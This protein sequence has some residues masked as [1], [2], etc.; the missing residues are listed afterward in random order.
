MLRYVYLMPFLSIRLSVD[1]RLS[2]CLGCCEQCSGEH[3]GACTFLEHSF[4]WVCAQEWD[5]WIM[6]QL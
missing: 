3:R 4:V 5:F 1:I 6:Q 2:P